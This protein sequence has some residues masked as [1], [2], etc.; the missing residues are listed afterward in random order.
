[1][2]LFY[3]SKISSLLP[4]SVAVQHKRKI[5]NRL[6]SR[7]EMF[8]NICGCIRKMSN[9]IFMAIYTICTFLKSLS[10]ILS[11]TFLHVIKYITAA[12]VHES[13]S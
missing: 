3:K 6:S 13:H 4:S 1:M 9:A 11:L 10:N 12:D 7:I 2:P 8:R 5:L